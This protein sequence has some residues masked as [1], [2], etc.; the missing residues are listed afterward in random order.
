MK[1][2]RKL[3]RDLVVAITSPRHAW[4]FLSETDPIH[5]LTGKKLTQ[6]DLREFGQKFEQRENTLIVRTEIPIEEELSRVEALPDYRGQY[7]EYLKEL[8]LKE[9]GSFDQIIAMGV[10]EHIS[11]P[12][13]L[14]DEC[15]RV[16]SDGGKLFISA[17]SVFSIHNGPQNYFHVTHYGMD[18]LMQSKPWTELDISGSCGPFKT[19]GILLQRILLQ[20]RIN[21]II[22]LPVA[23]LAMIIPKLD[24]FV[25]NQ[26]HGRALT[27]ENE[28]D[29]MLP[30]N[31]HMVATK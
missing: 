16:L 15:Y 4:N 10:L 19:I 13:R 11:E 1:P 30:S 8:E 23:I 9:D 18:E 3:I 27:D 31:I 17:S 28:I 7:D 5:Y 25:K 29:S 2:V 22:R 12:Q 20:T 21:P 14:I 6:N 26:Y 24:Y